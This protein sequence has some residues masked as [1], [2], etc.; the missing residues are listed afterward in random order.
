M[1]DATSLLTR[2]V[3]SFRVVIP[4]LLLGRLQRAACGCHGLLYCLR[5]IHLAFD[6]GGLNDALDRTGHGVGR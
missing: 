4:P 6:H 1:C 5:R 3:C 2:R